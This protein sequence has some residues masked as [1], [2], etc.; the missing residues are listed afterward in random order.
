VNDQIFLYW[1]PRPE[2]VHACAERYARWLR[3]LAA[4]EPFFTTWYELGWSRR[5][6]LRKPVVPTTEH[7]ERL[8]AASPTRLTD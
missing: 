5:D 4:I 6:A 3:D 2:S 8:L 1:G 7:L